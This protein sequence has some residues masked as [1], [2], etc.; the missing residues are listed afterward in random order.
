MITEAINR[1]INVKDLSLGEPKA[2]K[3]IRPVIDFSQEPTFAQELMGYIPSLPK[4]FRDALT[5]MDN[6]HT[7]FGDEEQMVTLTRNGRTWK[8]FL[9][10]DFMSVDLDSTAMML[11][12]YE[13]V[14]QARKENREINMEESE[15]IRSTLYQIASREENEYGDNLREV[16]NHPEV[17]VWMAE[18]ITFQE[19]TLSLPDYSSPEFQASDTP[20]V[21][22]VR[23]F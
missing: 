1:T 21:P 10:K 13:T 18:A 12:F 16:A 11:L 7:L 23:K 17:L 8:D 22:V 4:K 2:H 9:S 15:R 5:K 19:S 3:R 14:K 20:E 6:I